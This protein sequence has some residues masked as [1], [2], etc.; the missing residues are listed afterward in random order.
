MKEWHTQAHG[1]KLNLIIMLLISMFATSC[2]TV[3]YGPKLLADHSTS[4]IIVTKTGFVEMNV[5]GYSGFRWDRDLKISLIGDFHINYDSL[6]YKFD[7]CSETHYLRCSEISESMPT[8]N[9]RH[10]HR[11]RIE[12]VVIPRCRDVIN[13]NRQDSNVIRNELQILP[14]SFIL[15]NGSTVFA[16]TLKFKLW[17]ATE[18]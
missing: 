3:W 18:R 5:Y 2:C 11:K 13:E 7:N 4:K 6:K 9:K 12:T 16:D 17:V 15:S 8:D 1:G 14:S 10:L